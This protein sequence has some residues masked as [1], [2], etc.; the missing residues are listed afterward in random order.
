MWCIFFWDRDRDRQM[1]ALCKTLINNYPKANA[2]RTGEL[3]FGLIN[4][5]AQLATVLSI[6]SSRVQCL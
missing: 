4:K 2:E 1:A 5:L 3:A 6:W